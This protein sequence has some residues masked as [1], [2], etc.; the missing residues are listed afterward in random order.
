[1]QVHLLHMLMQIHVFPCGTYSQFEKIHYSLK[2]NVCIH[3]LTIFFHVHVLTLYPFQE[4]NIFSCEILPFGFALL[5]ILK[6]V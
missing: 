6:I 3:L 4:K 2:Y 5:T 1:M